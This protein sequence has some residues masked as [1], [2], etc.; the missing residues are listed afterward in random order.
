MSGKCLRGCHR[1]R[2]R[3]TTEA[4]LSRFVGSVKADADRYARDIGNVTRRVID[5]FAGNGAKLE[6][7]I[8]I[9]AT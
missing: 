8:N 9:Q 1:C 4:V 2:P 3:A 5:R 7:T 6:I